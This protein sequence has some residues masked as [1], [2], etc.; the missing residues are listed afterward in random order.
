ME[1]NEHALATLPAQVVPDEEHTVRVSTPVAGRVVSVDVRPGDRVSAGQSIA[2]IRSP[3]A[4]LAA[5]DVSKAAASLRVTRAA[6]ART[7]DLF[8]HKVSSARELEQARADEAQSRAE[9]E[10]AR[11]RATQ[12]GGPG[13]GVV[14]D[15]YVLRAPIAGVVIDR[16][17]NAG[18]EV[19][20][21]NGT[22]LFTI[23]SLDAVWLAVSVPQR[24]LSAVH[25]G[26][27]VSFTTESA[28]GR[29]FTGPVSFV[30]D[31]LDPATHMATARAVV[32]NPGGALHLLATGEV[33][34]VTTDPTASTVIPSRALVTHADGAVVFVEQAPGRFVRR[35]VIVR[36][37]DG[38]K[39]TIAEGVRSGERVVTTGSLMLS[40]EADRNH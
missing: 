39:A 38:T 31:A 28:P 35:P 40:A 1:S 37:D 20:P 21:D 12:L 24:D 18:A 34:I 5:S 30:S 27:K 2:H 8:E 15:I 26:A 13:I 3:D 32:A 29:T 22:A 6:L 33:R 23:S 4:A 25:R 17:T 9:Y 16:A 14:S 36:D 7:S 10:R 19:R 11:A